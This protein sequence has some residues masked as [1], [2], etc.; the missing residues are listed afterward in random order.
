MGGEAIDR[1][2]TTRRARGSAPLHLQS[3]AFGVLGALTG[4]MLKVL[5]PLHPQENHVKANSSVTS[6][7]KPGAVTRRWMWGGLERE[8]RYGSS[9]IRKERTAPHG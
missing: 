2:A 4:R 7:S 1:K 5:R 6:S 9:V 8:Q 3:S